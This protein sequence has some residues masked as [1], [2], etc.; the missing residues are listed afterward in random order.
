MKGF[1]GTVGGRMVAVEVYAEGPLV[2]QLATSVV[3]S[4]NQLTEWGVAP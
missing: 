4:P 3:L 2:G 1:I